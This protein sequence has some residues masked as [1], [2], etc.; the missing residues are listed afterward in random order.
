MVFFLD[1]KNLLARQECIFFTKL[2]WR[3]SKSNLQQLIFFL[4]I[5]LIS[6]E[7]LICLREFP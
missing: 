3:G 6:V 4:D 2:A 7:L 1:A 5:D